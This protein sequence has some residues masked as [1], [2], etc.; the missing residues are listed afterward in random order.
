MQ[1]QRQS[2]YVP[3]Q[4]ENV[5]TNPAQH[6]L[7]ARAD[8]TICDD[9]FTIHAANTKEGGVRDRVGETNFSVTLYY[10]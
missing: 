3:H 9:E 6:P 10:Y 5:K 1:Q 2:N 7:I 8:F 4:T